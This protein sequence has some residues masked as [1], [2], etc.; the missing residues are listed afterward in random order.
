VAAGGEEDGPK[1][2][3]QLRY[4][5]MS[6][7]FHNLAYKIANAPECCLLLEEALDRLVPQLEDKLNELATNAKNGQS[8]GQENADPNVQQANDLFSSAKLKKKEV[9]S[10]NLRRKLTWF[11]KLRKG[12]KPMKSAASTKRGAKVTC[13]CNMSLIFI[14][15]L[16]SSIF[17]DIGS[18]KNQRK[19]TVCSLKCKGKM[20]AP[21]KERVLQEQMRRVKGMMQL[22]ALQS[23]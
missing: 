14:P 16:S 17:I 1:L 15:K 21:R 23:S 22:I 19:K 4:K 7:K 12:R 6:H 13:V 5:D 18:N 11:D 3:A 20:V 2:E 9:P 8:S 10:K